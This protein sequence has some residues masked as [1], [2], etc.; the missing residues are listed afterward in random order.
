MVNVAGPDQGKAKSGRPWK[1]KEAARASS[2]IAVK[3][4][5]TSWEQKQAARAAKRMLKEHEQAFKATISSE[6]KAERERLALK[7]KQQEENEKK[8]SVVQVIKSATKLK[9]L[10]KKQMRNIKKL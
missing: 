7:H 8:T 10:S 5:K 9:R 1:H 3:S 4:V 2:R 6:K